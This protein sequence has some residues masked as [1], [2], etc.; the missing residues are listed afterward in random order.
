MD[1]IIIRPATFADMD[2]L[3]RFEQ[4]VITAERPFDSTLKDEHINY[5]DLVGMIERPDIELLVA[6]LNGELI[7]SGYARI[8]SS[9]IKWR[10]DWIGLRTY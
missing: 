6:E 10:I 9:G 7:G 4:G 1:E 5:Y 3:L 2:T 8:I